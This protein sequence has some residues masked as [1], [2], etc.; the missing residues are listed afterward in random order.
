[1]T[2]PKPG[3]QMP[4]LRFCAGEIVVHVTAATAHLLNENNT[5]HRFQSGRS[6]IHQAK[7]FRVVRL[8]ESA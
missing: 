8:D 1:M 7:A 4:T 6:Q 2:N 3:L 5:R